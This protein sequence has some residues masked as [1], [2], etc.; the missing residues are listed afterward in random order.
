MKLFS[1]V[2]KL[3]SGQVNSKRTDGGTLQYHKVSRFVKTGY[4]IN[5]KI[6]IQGIA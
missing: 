6:A 1:I 3:W 2:Q 5:N 4:K